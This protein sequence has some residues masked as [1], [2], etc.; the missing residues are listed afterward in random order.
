MDTTYHQSSSTSSQS[1]FA[2]SPKAYV[3]SAQSESSPWYLDSAASDH[4]THN[5]ANLSMYQ[6]YQGQEIKGN[7][8][9]GL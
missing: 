5:L 8:A 4:I 3:A 2:S 7:L 6:P 1:Q 9:P